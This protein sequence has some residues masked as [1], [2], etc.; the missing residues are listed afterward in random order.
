MTKKARKKR[1]AVFDI[2][3]TIF[4]S[5]LFIEFVNEMIRRKLFPARAYKEIEGDYHAWLN[6]RGHYAKYLRRVVNTYFRY[7]H[8]CR[9]KDADVV[10][11]Y[12]VRMQK[13]RVHRFTRNLVRQLRRK[14]YYLIALSGSPIYVVSRFARSMGFHAAL[15]SEHEV[16]RGSLT[17]NIVDA[18]A[19]PSFVRKKKMLRRH[20]ASAGIEPDWKHSVA[21][22][23][24]EGDIEILKLVGRPIAFNPSGA[25]A[26]YAQRHGWEIVVERK[27]V[28]YLIS[29]FK[30][31]HYKTS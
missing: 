29:R 21:V 19:G 22:G 14:G 1:I 30:M 5:S 20:L 31:V 23:D 28:A 11:R 9:E 8:G 17:R 24:T 7:I 3:G 16:K 26:H 6:R 27:D 18:L 2:D 15:G 4:R 12:V 10:A 25:L 13:D